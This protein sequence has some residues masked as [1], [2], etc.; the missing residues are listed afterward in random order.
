[1]REALGQIGVPALQELR[2]QLARLEG[3]LQ[4]IQAAIAPLRSALAEAPPTA[5]T[6]P[7]PLVP[8]TAPERPPAPAPSGERLSNVL[9][10]KYE[11]LCQLVEY[12]DGL[13]ALPALFDRVREAIPGL[14]TAEFHAELQ[15]LWDARQVELHILN[16]VRDA[17][18][19]DLAI[20]RNDAVYY[21]VL[22]RDRR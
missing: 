1:M 22:W 7:P 16:E 11:Y 4:A 2:A 17:Q 6:P 14:T 5:P 13:V 9:Q 15:R 18:R 19:L 21:F 3:T 8:T 20:R 12:E 10:Q